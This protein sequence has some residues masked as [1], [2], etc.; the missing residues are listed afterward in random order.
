MYL[1]KLEEE[2][3][4]KQNKLDERRGK[5]ISKVRTEINKLEFVQLIGKINKVKRWCFE[6]ADKIEIPLTILFKEDK[7]RQNSL[8]QKFMKEHSTNIEDTEE[9]MKR[10][11]KKLYAN[12]LQFQ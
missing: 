11:H 12:I 4:E 10:H 1:K 3:K 7:C 9:V 5:G 8:F 2:Q 6:K